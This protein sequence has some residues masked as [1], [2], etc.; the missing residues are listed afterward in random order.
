MPN[1]CEQD[2]F[3]HDPQCGVND[4][5]SARLEQFE[6]YA[7]YTLED[8]T[9]VPLSAQRFV[10][11]PDDLMVPSGGMS[12]VWLVWHGSDEAIEKILTQPRFQNSENPPR[13]REE[14]KEFWNQRG[15]ITEFD[16]GK[17]WTPKELADQYEHNLQN[18]GHMD[19]YSW[20]RDNWGTKWGI[21]E[22]QLVEEDDEMLTYFF[23]SAWSP[24]ELVV[25][26]M[27]EAFP[28]LQFELVWFEAGMGVNGKMEF[29]ARE[30]Q[31][32]ESGKYFG[33]R[34]G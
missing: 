7:A 19:W 21:V 34:G 31:L 30:K 2:L 33:H 18:Y 26:A 8:G 28:D 14:L 5:Q 27:S 32:D 3:V 1:W 10:P 24:A 23:V 25:L 11:M 17:E 12:D 9:E 16:T 29:Y 4:G 6:R 22:P 15:M 13:N 20:A